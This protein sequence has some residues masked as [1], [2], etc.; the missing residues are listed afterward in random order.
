[1]TLN[2]THGQDKKLLAPEKIT[3]LIPDRI[4]GFNADDGQSKIIKLGNIRYSLVEKNFSS[5]KKSIKLLL[6]DYIEAPIMFQQ[7][8]REWRKFRPVNSDSLEV[9]HLSIDGSSGWETIIQQHN[10]TQIL[11]GINDRF[12]MCVEAKYID[13]ETLR[14][15]VSG[16]KLDTYP[17]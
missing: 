5:G 12:Y 10:R 6:F 16:F 17:R 3:K 8:T 7:L 14:S 9:H 4:K 1:M 2:I 11:L 13:I 15:I